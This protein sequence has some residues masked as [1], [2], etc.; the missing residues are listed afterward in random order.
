MAKID[1]FVIVYP[2]KKKYPIKTANKKERINLNK[3]F[4]NILK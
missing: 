4:K 3:N 2:L 1:T